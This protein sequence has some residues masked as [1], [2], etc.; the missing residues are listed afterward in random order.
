MSA[1]GQGKT[2]EHDAPHLIT[3]MFRLMAM[4]RLIPRDKQG[5]TAQVIRDRLAAV[6][7][8][9]QVDLRTVQRNLE[10]IEKKG[11]ETGEWLL[12]RDGQRP[13]LW[14]WPDDF[15]FTAPA[16]TP[17]VALAF[18][19][20]EAHLLQL[21]PK[22]FAL[23]L[24]P[25]IELARKTLHASGKAADRRLASWPNKVAIL[26]RQQLLAPTSL[27][28]SILQAIYDALLRDRQL[29]ACYRPLGQDAR[30]YILNPLGLVFRGN[31][32]YLLAN[33]HGPQ[34]KPYPNALQFTLH[35]FKSA[36]VLEDAPVDTPA[37]LS[38][39]AELKK[40]AFGYLR[41]PSP[42]HLVA[43]FDKE[44]AQQFLESRLSEDQELADLPD[45]RIQLAAT[46][47]N[48]WELYWW[49]MGFG[50]HVEVLEPDFLRQEIARAAAGMYA[51]YHADSTAGTG[52]NTS[53]HA[54][55]GKKA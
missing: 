12:R 7:E 5:L 46:V 36:E 22:E 23:E 44:Q 33:N 16:M 48:T 18:L 20:I 53:P 21:L 52:T 25:Y 4:L 27:Q 54:G 17:A 39:Q 19:V 38:L 55:S 24:K 43:L 14:S 30:D 2:D 31:T 35:R 49:L 26:P 40:G 1:I 6:H 15:L 32:V 10:W 13:S 8:D 42:I 9:Y 11:H 50:P 41:E 47:D 3:V 34:G 29:K 28:P 45:G 37:N 51:I